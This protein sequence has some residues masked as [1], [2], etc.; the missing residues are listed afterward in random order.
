VSPDGAV[1]VVKRGDTL[2]GIAH[3]HGLSLAQL[4]ALNPGLFDAAH[5]GGNLI[6]PGE[7][8]RL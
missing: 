2:S 5:R 7:R 4:R 3:A 8:V 1:H 6:I